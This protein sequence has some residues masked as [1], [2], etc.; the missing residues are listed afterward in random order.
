VSFVG[1]GVMLL[2]V[3][4][5]GDAVER[6]G[7]DYTF[8]GTVVDVFNKFVTGSGF[9]GPLRYVVQDDRGILMIM[10]RKDFEKM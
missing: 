8:N 10:S 2:D 9:T 3:I 5:K 7:D 4:V 1:F 6:V